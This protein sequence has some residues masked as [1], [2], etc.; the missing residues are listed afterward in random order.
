MMLRVIMRC[1]TGKLLKQCG[2]V[3]HPYQT[4]S[5]HNLRFFL[6]KLGKMSSKIN[7]Q[8]VKI[9]I[10]TAF[11][12]HISVSCGC[13]KEYFY[14]SLANGYLQ[15]RSILKQRYYKLNNLHKH[16]RA[17]ANTLILIKRFFN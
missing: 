1:F 9:C 8:G 17:D 6:I 11:N 16:D 13:L 4:T 12:I 7:M 2:R 15:T 3:Y 10:G 5:I 14:Y